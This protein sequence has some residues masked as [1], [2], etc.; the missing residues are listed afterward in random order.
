MLWLQTGVSERGW[1]CRE[2]TIMRV[3][4]VVMRMTKVCG[5]TVLRYDARRPLYGGQRRG[6]G[7]TGRAMVGRPGAGSVSREVREGEGGQ[8]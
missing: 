7:I 4:G 3:G 1:V 2:E 8:E 6:G 5:V